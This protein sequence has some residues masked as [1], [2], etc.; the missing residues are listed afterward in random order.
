MK[1]FVP[2]FCAFT[3]RDGIINVLLNQF[4]LIHEF[5]SENYMIRFN[6]KN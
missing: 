5:Q 4:N 6:V 2:T 1:T 3:Y